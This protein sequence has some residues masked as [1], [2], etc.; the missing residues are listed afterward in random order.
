MSCGRWS[1]LGVMG[2]PRRTFRRAGTVVN[3]VLNLVTLLSELVE[4]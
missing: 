3:H 4:V 1:S 2:Q